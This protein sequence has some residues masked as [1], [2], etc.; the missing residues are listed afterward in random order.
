MAFRAAQKAIAAH[1]F[2]DALYCFKI[3]CHVLFP[4]P[5]PI[6][7]PIPKLQKREKTQDILR[8]ID[9]GKKKNSFLKCSVNEPQDILCFLTFLEFRNR[10]LNRIRNRIVNRIRNRFGM[11]SKCI[12]FAR[13]IKMV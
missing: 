13:K 6:P 12:Q 2:L 5:N 11:H 9:F 1:V 4:I 7:N 8:F 10:F 3:S